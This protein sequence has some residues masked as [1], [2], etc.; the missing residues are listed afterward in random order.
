MVAMARRH[1]FRGIVWSIVRRRRRLVTRNGG[2]QR[3]TL[4]IGCNQSHGQHREREFEAPH[5]LH[6]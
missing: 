4:G 3:N 1:I 2:A 5:H 6:L